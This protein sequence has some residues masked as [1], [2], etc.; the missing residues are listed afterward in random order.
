MG[1]GLV[2]VHGFAGN[3]AHMSAI[4]RI[5][6]R[7]GF[8]D[9]V[10]SLNLYRNNVYT[11]HSP[12][13]DFDDTTPVLEGSLVES[14]YEQ[15][16]RLDFFSGSLH[17]LGYSLGGLVIRALLKE[18]IKKD[19]GWLNDYGPHVGSVLMLAT[20]N[21]GA[22]KEGFVRRYGMVTREVDQMESDSLFLDWLNSSP[23]YVDEVPHYSMIGTQNNQGFVDYDGLVEKKASVV[24]GIKSVDIGPVSDK[25]NHFNIIAWND[26]EPATK[27]VKDVVLDHYYTITDKL[28]LIREG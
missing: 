13:I 6:T 7:I 24:P 20:P 27:F 25:I 19:L 28:M 8:F 12:I 4:H 23:N 11:V 26:R 18:V 9:F 22:I 21:Q 10:Y 14:A 5:L 1:H 2:I 3:S 16:Q 15:L 17:F